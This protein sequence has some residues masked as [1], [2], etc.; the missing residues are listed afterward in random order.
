MHKRDN[1][2]DLPYNTGHYTQYC[3]MTYKE[4]ESEKVCITE[5]LFCT[6]EINTT[7]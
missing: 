2:Q 7:L 6:P 1:Q 5:S 3:V 4:K